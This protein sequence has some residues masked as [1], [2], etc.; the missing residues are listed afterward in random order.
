MIDAPVLRF[1]D[2]GFDLGLGIFG[3]IR[4]NEVNSCHAEGELDLTGA[5]DQVFSR[6]MTLTNRQDEDSSSRVLSVSQ[7]LIP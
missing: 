1:G 2:G 7:V 3:D 4:G 5:T 6:H